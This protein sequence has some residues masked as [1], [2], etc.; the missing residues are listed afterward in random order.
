MRGVLSAGTDVFPNTSLYVHGAVVGSCTVAADGELLIHGWL[1]GFIDINEGTIVVA[2]EIDMPL[3]LVPGTLLVA[4]GTTV[5]IDGQ[6]REITPSGRLIEAQPVGTAPVS[7]DSLLVREAGARFVPQAHSRS[8]C[9][10]AE[11]V[12]G[13]AE[14]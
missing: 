14:S 12:A 5:S 13:D 2:G 10:L 4:A 6:R 9:L 11:L 7:T 8:A 3:E 1:S